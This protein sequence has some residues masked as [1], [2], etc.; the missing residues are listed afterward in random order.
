MTSTTAEVM[1]SEL[2]EQHVDGE[3]CVN[4]GFLYI[5]N[6]TT[7]CEHCF[8]RASLE[9]KYNTDEQDTAMSHSSASQTRGKSD[10]ENYFSTQFC[11]PQNGWREHIC[12]CLINKTVGI[13]TALQCLFSLNNREKINI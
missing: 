1:K 11:S 4:C 6:V 9:Q 12:P 10:K 3:V 5:Y 8:R 13:Y 7:L 2:F